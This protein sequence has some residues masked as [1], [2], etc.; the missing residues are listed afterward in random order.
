MFYDIFLRIGC[1]R[2][3][4][5]ASLTGIGHQ[6]AVKNLPHSTFMPFL[7]LDMSVARSS[8]DILLC[9]RWRLSSARPSMLLTRL[10]LHSTLTP[11]R[12]Q[13]DSNN[14][15]S[16]GVALYGHVT[17]AENVTWASMATAWSRALYDEVG[18]RMMLSFCA[19]AKIVI[20][21]C[22]VDLRR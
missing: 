5:G 4:D 9:M 8:L 10:A 16:M 3:F 19:T 14:K 7:H 1:G 12:I 22:L 6:H 11:F 21:S 15:L 18:W 17:C 20:K 13:R 2:V